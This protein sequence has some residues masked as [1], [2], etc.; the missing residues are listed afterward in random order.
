MPSQTGHKQLLN[1]YVMSMMFRQ[2]FTPP[3]RR[4]IKHMRQESM[5]D[6]DS[7]IAILSSCYPNGRH[8][9]PKAG[10]LHLAWEYAQNPSDHHHFINMLCVTP[11]VFQTILNLIEEHPVFT[12]HSNNAQTPVEQ[13]LAVTLYRMGRCGNGASLEDISHMAGCSEGSPGLNGDAYYT[14]KGNYGLNAQVIFP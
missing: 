12:N 3:E 2:L 10:D 4:T 13:Q 11:L 14:W 1:D 7:L 8:R 6:L 5:L 9:V